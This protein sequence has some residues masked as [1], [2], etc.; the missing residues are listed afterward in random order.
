MNSVVRRTLTILLAA[1]LG[2]TWLTV[3]AGPAEA[4][5]PGYL[6]ETYRPQYHY[7]AEKDMINDP[8]GLVYLDGEWHLFHQYNIHE[9][10]H[11]GHAVSTDLVHWKRLPPALFPDSIGQIYSGTVVVDTADTSGLRT[12][13][14][15]VMVALFTY[16]EHRLGP[17]SQ[18]L[19]YS[20]DRGR[21]WTMHPNNPVIPNS[22]QADFRDPKVFWHAA[23]ARWVMLLTLGKTLAFY[24]STNLNSWERTGT[25]GADETHPGN[26]ECP[27]LFEMTVPGTGTRRWVLS[28]SQDA[29]APQGGVGMRYFVGS[30]DG[31]TFASDN[32]AGTEL[33]QNYG[34]D[35]YA[36][37]TFDNV[38]ARDGRRLMV[39]WNDNWQYRFDLP[40]VPFNGQLSLVRELQLRRYPEGLRLTQ[41]PAREYQQVR[42]TP[43]TW[44]RH[45]LRPGTNLTAGIR[46]DTAE[47]IA[48]FD[49]ARSTATRFGLNVRVGDGGQATP[50]GYDK[51]TSSMFVDRTRSGV[52]PNP[53]GKEPN[54]NWAGNHQAPLVPENGKI[55]LR[56]FV[57]RSSVE[58]FGNGRQQISDLILPDRTST[59]LQTFA[60]DGTAQLESLTVFPL[61]RTFPTAAP[62][63]SPLQNWTTL[64]G[65][66][67]DTRSGREG[68]ADAALGISLSSTHAS[69]FDV[70]G[71]VTIRGVRP[72]NPKPML[73]EKSAGYA[74]RYD[75]VA[76]TG[77]LVQLDA[78]TDTVS[79]VRRDGPA[80]TTLARS[81]VHVDTNTAYRVGATARGDQLTVTVDGRT[82]FTVTDGAY[83]DGRLGLVV[84]D[85]AAAIGDLAVTVTSRFDTNLAGWA[86][87]SGEWARTTTGLRGSSSGDGFIMS[88]ATGTDFTLSSDINIAAVG[89]QRA[90]TLVF[91]A[92]DAVTQ[93]Y[94]LNLDAGADR[95][96]LFRWGSPSATLATV[97]VNVD[98]GRSYRLTVRVQGSTVTVWLDN[99][100]LRSV[101]DPGGPTTGGIGL[102]TYNA[103]VTFQNTVLTELPGRWQPQAGTWSATANGWRGGSTDDGFLMSATTAD[104][105]SYHATVR[106]TRGHAAALVFRASATVDSGY[107]ANLDADNDVV[108]L[109]RFNPGSDPT[110]LRRH[111]YSLDAN[112]DYQLGVRAVDDQIVVTLDDRDVI[113]VRDN[114]YSNG[115]L[116][117]N[118]WRSDAAFSDI[119]YRPADNRLL[120]GDFERGT[121]GAWTAWQPNGQAPALGVDDRDPA[122]GDFK[123]YFYADQEFQQSA[124]QKVSGLPPG[125]YTVSARVKLNQPALTARLEVGDNGHPV[126]VPITSGP[127]YQLLTTTVE[128][129]TGALDIGFYLH[130]PGRT[131]LQIDD[132]R[133]TKS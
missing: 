64:S 107:V 79:L 94:G 27:D 75:T 1:V 122:T 65:A 43:R 129:S 25:W 46:T 109:F 105:L 18:G 45:Q 57:D 51:K 90:G 32:P 53:T 119:T 19:A 80:S 128:V 15:P 82:S 54:P 55:T 123:L 35:F 2:L 42:G 115:H 36:G 8:N 118:T 112:R 131:S 16:A 7:T 102:G 48:T 114:T 95:V 132:V 93:G 91:R 67:A 61:K 133:V 96:T 5:D 31:T 24:T 125:R 103:T 37:I 52:V 92:D 69:D 72:G 87:R 20:N 99:T 66:W 97:P 77:Y 40:T 104:N 13:A 4:V 3:P 21:T 17:Q 22:G 59:A 108:T 100:L 113:A 10:I 130:G 62:Q 116:G 6:D 101:T 28:V 44:G 38:P 83:R 9:A 68:S 29:G 89:S 14:T 26:W 106:V 50:I 81:S 88:R 86:T 34:K 60:V 111:V 126:D 84:D 39:A 71:D 49:V 41:R 117:L 127:S 74:L 11:W 85:A 98:T 76:G 47:I 63:P 110:T 70:T 33:W 23:T 73:G 30:F 12:G 78:R 56:I 121:L 120:D 58:V 124:H